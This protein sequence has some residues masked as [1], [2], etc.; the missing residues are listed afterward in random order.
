MCYKTQGIKS[1]QRKTFN[2]RFTWM[3]SD[4][5]VISKRFFTKKHA[6]EVTGMSYTSICRRLR[7]MTVPS[8][9]HFKIDKICEPAQ[10]IQFQQLME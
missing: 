1:D 4:G 8:Y 5:V 10:I 9:A 2:L 3:D 7:G 6:E